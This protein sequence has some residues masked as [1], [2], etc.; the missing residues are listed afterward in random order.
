MF[1]IT[2]E[3]IYYINLRQAFLMSPIYAERMSSRTVLYTSVPEYY[4][5][6]GRL[7]NMLG[8]AVKRVWIPTDTKELDDLV[9]E[10]DKIS[11]KLEGAETKLCKLAHVA[12]VKSAGGANEEAAVTEDGGESGS[13][14]A[15][16]IRPKDRPTHRL[17][18]LIGKKVDTINWSRTEL[19]K[20]IPKVRSEQLKHRNKEAKILN[21]VFV[22]FD[23]VSEAQAAYQSLTH[24]QV[25]HMAPR[26]T[27]LNPEEV[28]WSN[29]RIK[30]WERLIRVFLTTTFVV[31]LVVFWSIPVAFVGVVSQLNYLTQ[32]LPWLGWI[33]D[34]PSAIVGVITGLLPVIMLAVLMALLPI[35]LRRKFFFPPLT[36]CYL[37]F[38]LIRMVSTVMARLGGAP[39]LSQI[40]LTTQNFYFAFQVV[41]VF[42]VATLSSSASAAV[43]QIIDNPSSVT[44][45]LAQSI[46]KA[47]N[48]YLSYIILQGLG[49][50]AGLL[51]GLVGLILSMVLGKLLDKTPR[52]MYKRWTSLA[53][54]GWG[55]VFPIYTNLF[56]I[57]KK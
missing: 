50:V 52:K 9:K 15:R 26:Y 38:L 18:P 33:N 20:L 37:N 55:T 34:M 7:R 51:V 17:K 2:R 27:G 13:V 56:V 54:L 45:L 3:S 10:R 16:W 6:E 46:P 1:M 44:S 21:S 22:E 19:E 23:S 29:L 36:P 25:L 24:H 5:D 48:F 39:T 12:K 8:R 35:I 53:G 41:Q 40:E 28:I 31:A 11:M 42:L 47:S 43:Q 30:W 14:A 32:K 57:G 4:L 49:V